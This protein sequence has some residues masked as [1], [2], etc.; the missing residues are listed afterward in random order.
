MKDVTFLASEIK[1]LVNI[2]GAQLTFPTRD[3]NP[4]R[5]A[6][7]RLITPPRPAAELED[8]EEVYEILFLF[9][10]EPH[11]EAAIV[12]VHQ[13]GQIAGETVGEVGR[14]GGESAELLHPDGADIRAFSGDECT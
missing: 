11:L 1:Q 14:A 4:V 8:V 2:G 9:V 13:F 5:C 7:T 6:A 3:G 10:C 12:E